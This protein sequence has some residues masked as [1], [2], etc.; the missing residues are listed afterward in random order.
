MIV[1]LNSSKTL[2]FDPT[3]GISKHTI[4]EFLK[5]SALLV[6]KLRKLSASE[7]S[8]LMGVSKKLAK[9]NVARYADWQT[10]ATPANAK[11]ALFAF[12]GDIYSGIET[13]N[14]KSRDFDFAQKHVR[15]LSGLYGIL[16]PLSLIQPYR[17]EMA[18]KLPT[19]EGRNLYSFWGNRITASLKAL[20]K[21][22]KSGVIVNL[23][24]AEYFRAVQSNDLEATIITP[25][26]KE[27][28]HGTYRFVTIYGKKARGLM[29]NYIIQNK[30]VRIED[31]KS[32]DSEGYQ[33]NKKISS[34]HEWLFTRGEAAPD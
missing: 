23:C 30:L 34:D 8:K 31:L 22:E 19:T 2:D 15:I 3:V 26:F 12:K 1:L 16:R 28:R 10:A 14:Y 29:C 18:A 21:Q 27:F 13:E 32:F 20:L 4:P 33:Y 24:S 25:A 7:I 6:E 11:Q 5:E 17:L 9:L